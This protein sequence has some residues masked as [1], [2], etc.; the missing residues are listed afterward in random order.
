[1]KTRLGRLFDKLMLG[2]RSLLEWVN[3][4]LTH[5]RQIEPT[6]HHCVRGLMETLMAG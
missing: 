3:D 2:P 4:P 1:M 5:I 6:R